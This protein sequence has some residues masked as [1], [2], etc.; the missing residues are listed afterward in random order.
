MV[1]NVNTG[2]LTA[3]DS[4]TGQ[5]I[6]MTAI[7]GGKP[8]GDHIPYGGYEILDQAQNPDFFRL[9]ALDKKPRNDIHE[10]TGRNHFRLHK[11]GRTVGCVA[12]EDQDDWDKL[13]N[14]LNNTN[15]YDY[16]K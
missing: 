4:E 3:T 6:N 15:N 9:D 14:M 7:S 8:Y 5:E 2:Q 11:P 1:Y 10:P 13:K 12:A 16:R